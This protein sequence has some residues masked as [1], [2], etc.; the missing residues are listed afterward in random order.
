M[1]HGER[2]GQTVELFR[3]EHGALVVDQREDCRLTRLKVVAEVD[4]LASLIGKA[5]AQRNLRIE[6]LLHLGAV[7][8]RGEFVAVLIPGLL[9]AGGRYLSGKGRHQSAAE[10]EHLKQA[11][12]LAN[13]CLEIHH[14]PFCGEAV[15]TG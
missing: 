2:L 1:D 10:C 9:V 13:W 7:E 3:A 14:C 12:G 15:R 11:D 5:G 4:R 8:N 6:M